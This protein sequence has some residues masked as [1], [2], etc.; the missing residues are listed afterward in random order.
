[1]SGLRRAVAQSR[2][3]NS[4]TRPGKDPELILFGGRVF[5]DAAAGSAPATAVA[6]DGGLIIAVGDDRLRELGGPR[7]R[8]VDLHGRLLVP[9]FQDAHAH[10]VFGALELTLCNLV[11]LN[12]LGQY[13]GAIAEYS[14]AHPGAEPLEGNGWTQAPF[15]GGRPTAALLDQVVPDRPILL[16]ANDG[17]RAWVNSAALA[18]AGIGFETP[19]PSDGRIERDESGQPTGVLVDGAAR[20]VSSLL[21]AASRGAL[22]QAVERAQQHMHSFGVT[23]WQDAILSREEDGED[24]AE[25]YFRADQAGRLTAHVTGA[26]WWDRRRGLEQIPDLIEKRERFRGTRFWTPAV[27]IMQDGIIE[28]ETASLLAP[29]CVPAEHEG[30]SFVEPETLN[31]AAVALE[32]AGFQM[33]FHGIGDRAVREALDAISYAKQVRVSGAQ[34]PDLRHHIAHVQLIDPADITRFAALNVTANIQPYW[35]NNDPLMLD[36]TVP[37]LGPERAARQYPFASLQAAGARLAAGSD[38]PVTTPD[39]IAGMHVAVNRV[40]P[41]GHIGRNA[42]PLCSAESLDLVSALCAYT[43]GSAYVNHRDDAGRIA[44][45]YTA[46]LVVLDRDLLTVPPDEIGTVQVEETFVRGESV[47][48][49]S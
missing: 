24:P 1:M 37:V 13:L 29:Y 49:R 16:W 18:T 22:D 38:W 30:L 44:P 5:D 33:H 26:L 2:S 8:S 41:V 39:P 6:V 4:R 19:D 48:V 7:T 35:A 34:V 27:K 10:P 12:T 25:A 47:Y 14:R 46:D 31:A 43:S 36:E 28:S 11:G 32:A 42:E 3:T 15:K 45:G 40:L 23:A 20:R 9:G 21:P 17:H